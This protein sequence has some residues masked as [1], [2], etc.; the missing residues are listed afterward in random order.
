MSWRSTRVQV[1]KKMLRR[2]DGLGAYEMY[3]KTIPAKQ[4]TY[5]PIDNRST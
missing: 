3:I 1:M 5:E 4:I 2:Q